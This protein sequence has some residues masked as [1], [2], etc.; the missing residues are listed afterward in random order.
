MQ[1]PVKYG[2]DGC[3]VIYGIY[4]NHIKKQIDYPNYQHPLKYNCM[5]GFSFPVIVPVK[6]DHNI[7]EN[8]QTENL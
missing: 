4:G 7:Y 6:A 2:I 8:Y 1:K 3:K 5:S